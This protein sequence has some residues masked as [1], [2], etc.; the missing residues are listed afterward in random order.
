MFFWQINYLQNLMEKGLGREGGQ[1]RAETVGGIKQTKPRS[2]Q[3]LIL[4]KRPPHHIHEVHH[5]LRFHHCNNADLYKSQSL[6][7]CNILDSS[8][9]SCFL[10]PNTFLALLS[11]DTCNL[12]FSPQNKSLC[13]TLIQN[14]EQSHYFIS[15]DLEHFGK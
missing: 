6:A 7:F 9:T 3:F 12:H 5:K 2:L 13:S 8:L 14:I 11:S 4:P 1:E 10:D 15:P